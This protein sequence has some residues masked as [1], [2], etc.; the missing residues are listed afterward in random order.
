MFEKKVINRI[1]GH[2]REEEEK[3]ERRKLHTEDLHNLY[4][5]SNIITVIE[6]RRR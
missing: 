1:L 6:S 3:E 4:S 5:S 2:K